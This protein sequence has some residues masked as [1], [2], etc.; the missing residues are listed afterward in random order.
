MKIGNNDQA[1][2][3]RNEGIVFFNNRQYE[4]ALEKFKL[5]YQ[6]RPAGHHIRLLLIQSLIKLKRFDEVSSQH[7]YFLNNPPN[8]ILDR[9]LLN[10]IYNEILTNFKPTDYSQKSKTYKGLHEEAKKLS[11][12]EW[13]ACVGKSTE[14]NISLGAVPMPSAPPPEKQA[15]FHGNSGQSGINSAALVYRY[16]LDSCQKHG[17]N[18]INTL[19]DF[20]CG[21]G[22]F[23]R[24]FVR[25]VNEDGLIG[26][27]PWD[28]ALQMCREH[29]PYAA[30]VRSQYSPPLIF[31]NNSFDVVF[32]NS[33]FSHLS[34]VN[35]LSWLKEV[36]RVLRP[37]GLLIGT[38]HSKHFLRTVQEFQN[39][40]R[41]CES[42][43]HRKLRDSKLDVSK[44]ITSHEK[45]EFIFMETVNKDYGD[46]FVS[47]QYIQ[48]VE[49]MGRVFGASRVC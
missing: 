43:W 41:P 39:G 1:D 38:T 35:G 23:T 14:E 37:G 36:A 5:A 4:N 9:P 20:G 15:I 19:L 18:S 30:F 32:A 48:K 29:M 25:D 21:W 47:K 22:R 42:T 31:S 45:G 10:D 7:Q 40:N 8:V 16:V 12:E 33:I 6:I 13:I 17:V 44:A 2:V 34:E 49:S 11:I 46:S 27:D 24:L 3:I 28:E 26:V